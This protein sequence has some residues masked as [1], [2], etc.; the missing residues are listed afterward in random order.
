MH[1]STFSSDTAQGSRA[2]APAGLRCRRACAAL[3]LSLIGLLL[4]VELLAAYAFPRISRIEGRIR[5][6][7]RE[8]MALRQR[9]P[10]SPPTILMVGNSLLLRGLD[11]PR[12]QADLAPKARV[13]RFVIENTDYIDWYYGLHRLFASGIRP[14]FVVLCLDAQQTITSQTLGD[15]SARHLFG[16]T[17]LIPAARAAKL[18][19]TD[20][21][22]LI[23]A[24][25]SAF[26]ASRATIRNF[27]LNNAAPGYADAL[28]SV[29]NGIRYLM[30]PDAELLIEAR[31]RLR[32][33][34]ELCQRNDV[35]LIFLIPP[36]TTGPDNVLATAAKLENV[37]FEYPFTTG[38]LSAALFRSDGMHLN[39]KGAEVFT[40]A[41]EGE[42]RRRVDGLRTTRAPLPSR[43]ARTGT[44]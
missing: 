25:W 24:H 9:A 12:I 38:A 37:D 34:N 6:D 16:A 27:I 40:Q 7:E 15:Y 1:S 39:E 30:P 17:E 22:G 23:L 14:N 32:R 4:V 3:F 44:P 10:N 42:L 5:D 33:V 20:T 41:I 21:S 2:N 31:S 18:D 35:P 36:S 28:H 13:V 26:Y 43:T 8:V 19:A 11:Y 29:A